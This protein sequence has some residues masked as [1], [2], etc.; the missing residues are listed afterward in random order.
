MAASDRA[1]LHALTAPATGKIPIA[2]T[3]SAMAATDAAPLSWS[4]CATVDSHL[5]WNRCV[6]FEGERPTPEEAAQDS[7]V[8]AGRHRHALGGGRDGDDD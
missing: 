3:T 4:G 1:M 7:D 6:A 5:P 8:S 2:L